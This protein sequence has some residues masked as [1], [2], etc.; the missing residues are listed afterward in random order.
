MEMEKFGPHGGTERSRRGAL[1]WSVLMISAATV[2]CAAERRTSAAQP[3]GDRKAFFIAAL[4]AERARITSADFVMEGR[5]S[6]PESGQ[7]PRAFRYHEA[8]DTTMGLRHVDETVPVELYTIDKGKRTRVVTQA[9][10]ILVRRPDCSMWW[11][12]SPFTAEQLTVSRPNKAPARLHEFWDADI[13]QAGIDGILAWSHSGEDP[14]RL[15]NSFDLADLV[16]VEEVGDGKKLVRANWEMGVPDTG[17]VFELHLWLDKAARYAPVR[18]EVIQARVKSDNSRVVFAR[19]STETSWE[20]L[21][22]VYVPAT[23]RSTEVSGATVDLTF[24]WR[25]LNSPLSADLFDRNHL[26]LRPATR[27]YDERGPSGRPVLIGNLAGTPMGNPVLRNPPPSPSSRR[28]W[29]I[30]LNLALVTVLA[31]LLY[32]RRRAARASR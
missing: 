32:L 19:T 30:G 22:G 24:S 29:I 10:L 26:G 1:I 11:F 16:S 7:K 14:R 21:N 6:D 28:W 8:F 15:Q 20:E 17:V 5:I 9:G 18:S 3:G 27:V 2:T 13:K 25:S 31:V 12:S 23:A 4:T